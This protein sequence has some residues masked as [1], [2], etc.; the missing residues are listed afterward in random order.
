MT[1]RQRLAEQ[2]WDDHR[3]YH[4]S[5]A[6]Q[7]LHFLSAVSF[8]CAYILLPIKPAA[9]VLLAWLLAMPSRQI[10]H[11]LFEPRTYDHENRATHEFKEAVKVGYNLRRKVVLMVVWGVSPLALLVDPTLGHLLHA[12]VDIW[13]TLTNVAI[14]WLALG[15]LAI[16]VRVIQLALLQDVQT[17]LVWAVKVLT[18]PFHDVW[19]YHKAPLQLLKGERL[20]PMAAKQLA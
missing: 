5:R 17:G 19:L 15:I 6:N 10:G 16:V 13:S 12:P 4:H 1:F 7:S 11:F 8:I 14:L 18:D 3:Y 9:A 20:D 2:R